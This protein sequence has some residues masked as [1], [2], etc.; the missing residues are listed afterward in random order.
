LLAYRV[1]LLIYP[2]GYVYP[3]EI[4]TMLRLVVQTASNY[5]PILLR[6]FQ[7]KSR[8]VPPDFKVD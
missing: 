6:V 3:E 1:V 2:R 7:G 8:A 4:R 5:L